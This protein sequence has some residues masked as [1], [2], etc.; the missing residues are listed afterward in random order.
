MCEGETPYYPDPSQNNISCTECE[1]G[2]FYPDEK[3]NKTYCVHS[4]PKNYYS[5]E[6]V[7]LLSN[8]LPGWTVGIIVFFVLLSIALFVLLVFCIIRKR[9]Q[10][11]RKSM[12]HSLD[13]SANFMSSRGSGK[14]NK[15]L[16]NLS[17]YSS[18]K[19]L[20]RQ[21]LKK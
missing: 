20:S 12:R 8:K 19:I 4:C 5:L 18:A 16:G 17:K 1:S 14:L 6:G 21:N 3:A 10:M 11:Q 7:C 13:S 9:R 15:S 2:I